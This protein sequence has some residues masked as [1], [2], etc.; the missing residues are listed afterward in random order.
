MMKNITQDHSYVNQY[1]DFYNK[2]RAE[3][4]A[5]LPDEINSARERALSILQSKG[6]PKRN[7]EDYKRFDVQSILEKDK[8]IKLNASNNE[9]NPYRSCRCHL[10]SGAAIRLGAAN[11][12]G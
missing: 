3:C 2:Y 12:E 7:E 10:G 9:Y 4:R 8:G 5:D 6:L 11:E 1:I